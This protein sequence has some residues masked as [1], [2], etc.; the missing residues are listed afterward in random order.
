MR[1][2]YL[3]D[4][5]RKVSEGSLQQ[6]VLDA[7]DAAFGRLPDDLDRMAQLL[8]AP[9]STMSARIAFL[10]GRADETTLNGVRRVIDR[11]RQVIS[12]KI[13][14]S[15]TWSKRGQPDYYAYV[16]TN[17]DPMQAGQLFVYLDERYKLAEEDGLD[18]R[19]LTLAHEFSHLAAK[20][21]DHA[22]AHDCFWTPGKPMGNCIRWSEHVSL[23]PYDPDRA[24]ENADCYGYL[25]AA[26]FRRTGAPCPTP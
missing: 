12:R 23:T 4:V 25:M 6:E 10:F 11:M 18:N 13:S 14:W 21:L 19:Y 2:S 20:T 5:T 17:V 7:T 26:T 24:V 22:Y 3:T 9:D 16:F 8:A 1:L 15:C